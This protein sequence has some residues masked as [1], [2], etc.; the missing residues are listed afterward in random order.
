LITAFFQFPFSYLTVLFLSFFFL[1]CPFTD[2]LRMFSMGKWK[3]K[4]QPLWNLFF[5]QFGI[6]FLGRQENRY[7]LGDWR[8]GNL[9]FLLSC[10]HINFAWFR[11]HLGR[12]PRKFMI[13]CF[14]QCCL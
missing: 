1:F 3:L 10:S 14:F 9:C 11:G 7:F 13:P 4:L 8:N 6:V 5:K 12:F 2:D